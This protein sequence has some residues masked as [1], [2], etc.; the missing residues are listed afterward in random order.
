MKERIKELFKYHILYYFLLSSGVYFI[1]EC[2][3]RRSLFKT[4][5]YLF[6]HPVIF[7]LNV[8]IVLW[9]Y[10]LVLL[11]KRKKFATIFISAL[12][13]IIGIVDFVLRSF[14]VTPFNASDITLIESAVDMAFVYMS[15]WQ[16]ALIVIAVLLFLS[17]II[18]LFIKLPKSTV[19]IKYLVALAT[20]VVTFFAVNGL[21]SGAVYIK[22]VPSK[23]GNLTEAYAEYGIS[24]CFA[25]SLL[26]MGISKPDNY[27]EEVVNGIV[28]DDIIPKE[29]LSSD[30][31]ISVPES[32]SSQEGLNDKNEVIVE[33][34][35]QTPNIIF[36]QLESF[37]DVNRIKGISFSQD[38]IPNFHSLQESYISGYLNVPSIGAGT[39]NTEFE[40]ITGMNLD[41]FGAGEYPYNT[42]LKSTVC[43][44]IAYNLK[45]IGYTA[46]AIH[47]NDGSFYNRNEVF[48]QLGFDKFIPMEYM[49]NY[50]VTSLGWIKDS[51]LVEEIYRTL[52]STEGVDYIYTIS[53][54]GHGAYPTED[55][56]GENK[57]I[58]V[59]GS[60][61]EEEK[62]SYEYYINQLYEMDLFIKRLTDLLASYDEKTV[63]VL[64]GDHLPSLGL[65]EED[66]TNQ[67][68]FQTEYII[69]SNYGVEGDARELE[70]YQLSAYVLEILNIHRGTM[71]CYHQN[72][73]DNS[74]TATDETEQ[75]YLDEMEILEYD[76]LYGDH[77]VYDGTIP[78]KATDLKF[79]NYDIYIEDI[80]IKD[81]FMYV[82]GGEFNEFS[83]IFINDKP[84]DTEF[85]SYNVL[86]A[87][88]ADLDIY[89]TYEVEVYQVGEDKTKLGGSGKVILKELK[90]ID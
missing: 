69:W 77:S 21:A 18:Y 57:V 40:L 78:Y 22:L 43:E 30:L 86:Y 29:T 39:A 90:P 11:V 16:I 74:D 52:N 75:N 35:E 31:L 48:S 24:Y 10:S 84:V 70:A 82:L 85:V 49:K 83:Q 56:L 59:S 26:N 7:L 19:K 28:K 1:T 20:V 80:W 44:S 6:T 81:N 55:V 36:L 66:L 53:V 73:F 88:D 89:D 67:N 38:P 32:D 42:V 25:N 79:G 15:W 41:F 58:T 61:S 71:M 63:L 76:I 14:R 13:L 9:T 5:G 12:W 51:V 45:D 68:L 23:F 37:F 65:T 3:S 17:I 54:Q 4:I 46:A 62:N 27:S 34:N 2:F 60:E 72:Y 87:P 8:I 64:Y 33:A 50:D 47:N